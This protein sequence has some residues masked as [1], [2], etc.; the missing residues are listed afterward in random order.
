MPCRVENTRNT[1]NYKNNK[2]EIP[3]YYLGLYLGLKALYAISLQRIK[4]Y[5]G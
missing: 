3:Q 1:E 2:L 4:A 5:M